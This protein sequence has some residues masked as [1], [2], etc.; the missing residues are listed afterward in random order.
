M[1]LA[2]V[3]GVS[4]SALSTKMSALTIGFNIYA[5]LNAIPPQRMREEIYV[6]QMEELVYKA[7]S[8]GLMALGMISKSSVIEDITRVVCHGL[9]LTGR[10]ISP[11]ALRGGDRGQTFQDYLRDPRTIVNKAFDLFSGAVAGYSKGLP[12]AVYAL[13]TASDHWLKGI[14]LGSLPLLFYASEAKIF[15][16]L[17]NAGYIDSSELYIATLKMDRIRECFFSL[18]FPLSLLSLGSLVGLLIQVRNAWDPSSQIFALTVP[19]FKAILLTG[20]CYCSG[21]FLYDCYYPEGRLIEVLERLDF[22]HTP[23]FVPSDQA[24]ALRKQ[25][26]EIAYSGSCFHLLPTRPDIDLI[27]ACQSPLLSPLHIQEIFKL[28]FTLLTPDQVQNV[29]EQLPQAL[30]P[31]FLL[32]QKKLWTI[33]NERQIEK[34]LISPELKSFEQGKKQELLTHLNALSNKIAEI[35]KLMGDKKLSEVDYQQNYLQLRALYEPIELFNFNALLEVLEN[36]PHQS[37]GLELVRQLETSI[38]ALHTQFQQLEQKIEPLVGDLFQYAYES[39]TTLTEKNIEDLLT[40]LNKTPSSH[41]FLRIQQILEH[42]GVKWKGDL[43]KESILQQGEK[44]DNSKEALQKRLEA[45][46]ISTIH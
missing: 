31:Y 32:T 37:K 18:K 9:Y 45:F 44:P 6:L 14:A 38:K 12:L 41:P 23:V 34:F 30:T 7:A 15:K 20:A 3:Q 25:L 27:K 8:L 33:L 11:L 22:V 17:L 4:I 26:L 21:K 5:R 13:S 43:L 35:E 39:L 28:Y 19:I 16:L 46:I 29:I 40:R 2:P 24:T 36:L 42:K 1:N 10:T